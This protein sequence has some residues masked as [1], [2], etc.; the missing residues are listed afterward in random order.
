MTVAT[1]PDN[2][3]VCNKPIRSITFHGTPWCGTRCMLDDPNHDHHPQGVAN[4][5][6]RA[7]EMAARAISNWF[8]AHKDWPDLPPA[9]AFELVEYLERRGWSVYRSAR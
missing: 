1:A 8:E 2:C 5:R 9:D 3:V 6:E 7:K 4:A